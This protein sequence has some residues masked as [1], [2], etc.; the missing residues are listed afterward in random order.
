MAVS[1]TVN[2][3]AQ[4]L[5]FL[6]TISTTSLKEICLNLDLYRIYPEQRITYYFLAVIAEETSRWA[7]AART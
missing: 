3:H 5:Y 7:D 4:V 1:E 6:E 2:A